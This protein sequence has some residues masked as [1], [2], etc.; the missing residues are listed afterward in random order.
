MA[1]SQPTAPP[2]PALRAPSP[3][4]RARAPR[5]PRAPRA[6]AVRL[7]A[8]A[9]VV[10]P[11]AAA[12][13]DEPGE[14]GPPAPV[15]ASHALEVVV[16]TLE[17]EVH[18]RSDDGVVFCA[19]WRE[20]RGFPVERA[21][22]AY[23]AVARSI[24]GGRTRLRFGSVE[25]GVAALACFH[26][27][28]ANDTL[29][30]SWVGIPIEGTAASNDARGFMGPPRFEDARFEIAAESPPPLTVRMHYGLLGGGAG[31]D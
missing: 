7:A 6:L 14:A 26:D 15:M 12:G 1:R 19:I 16:H 3:V 9:L 18:T 2:G 31:S 4:P 22:A 25:P 27:E 10:L 28:N 29:D 13:A 30:T 17:V 8:I 21:R 24:E 5:V 20:P 23:E 11:S